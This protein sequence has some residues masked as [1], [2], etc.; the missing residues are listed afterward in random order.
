[1]LSEETIKVV[2]ATAPILEEHGETLTRHFYKRMFSHNPE[3]APL[4][5]PANQAA[6]LQQKA[7]AGAICAYAANI[8]N[9]EALG[10]AVELIAQKHVSLQIQ[11]EHYPIVGENL[12]ASISEVLG[13]GATDE[14]INAWAEAYGFLADILIGREEQVYSE[15]AGV[16][17]G[18][19]G[20]RGFR[21]IRKDIESTVITSFYLSPVD[22]G[23][24]PEYK[25]G[26]YIT[27]RVKGPDGYT[28]M[29]NYSLSDKPGQDHFRIS[30]KRETGPGAGTPDGYVS[31]LLHAELGVGSELELVAPCGEFFLDV[32]EKHQRPLVL[33]AAGVGVTP[34]MSMLLSALEA[35]PGREIIFVHGA[36]DE[37][38]QAFRGTVDALAS[39]YPNLRVH[40]RYDEPAAAGADRSG[41]SSTGL[42]DAELIESLVPKRDAD[43]YF[44][45]PQPFMINIYHDLLA[46]GIPAAQVHL[47]FFGPRQA[48]EKSAGQ[49][50]PEAQPEVSRCPVHA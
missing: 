20:F 7:L 33:L 37:K 43:Y 41:S 35:M 9:L 39:Q 2:K 24:L 31:N 19:N 22:G 8:D 14:V 27:L 47:E 15:L 29:R 10:G 46:W 5:N 1:M 25:P 30:V 40:Y 34:L 49:D 38:S 17:G 42:V 18:W 50:V 3:V 45:G 44:C 36:Q 48:L 26:Q 6:G 11:P 23:E 28:T 21:I 13:E 12:L 32:T 4:F 16:P